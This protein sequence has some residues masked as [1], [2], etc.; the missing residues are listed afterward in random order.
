MLLVFCRLLKASLL[1]DMPY[2]R[3]NKQNPVMFTF[4]PRCIHFAE[5][6]VCVIYI[7]KDVILAQ[8][9]L[10]YVALLV[11]TTTLHILKKC[12]IRNME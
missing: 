11:P 6:G 7:Q 4:F 12:I 5:M 2:T 9:S 8:H 10:I 3:E 1:T